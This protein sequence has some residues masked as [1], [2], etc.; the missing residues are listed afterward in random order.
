LV[1]DQDRNVRNDREKR[2]AEDLVAH[3]KRYGVKTEARL[4]RSDEGDVSTV[5][6]DVTKEL[7][8][9]LLV[10]GAYS[11]ARVS[12][13]LFG[14]VTQWALKDACVPTLMSR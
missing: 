9:D 11:R 5:F 2:R 12:E 4:L 1:V 6:R 14:G 13:V 7:S 8:V 10:L 3:L